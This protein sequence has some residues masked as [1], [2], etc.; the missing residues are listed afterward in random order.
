MTKHFTAFSDHLTVVA[1]RLRCEQMKLATLVSRGE[2]M[3]NEKIRTLVAARDQLLRDT[4]NM[5]AENLPGRSFEALATDTHL[6]GCQMCQTRLQ[7]TATRIPVFKSKIVIQSA[8][9]EIEV[10]QT[11]ASE[12]QASGKSQAK[13]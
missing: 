4:H 13:T 3:M 2:D 10:S 11:T 5:G 7:S 9:P 6:C 12:K 1:E 8:A